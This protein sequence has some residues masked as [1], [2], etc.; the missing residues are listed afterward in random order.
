MAELYG[1]K[2]EELK[3]NENF[4]KYVKDALKSEK[5]IEFIVK[6]AKIK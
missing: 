2:E 3:E 1:K 4:V 5:V 6:N